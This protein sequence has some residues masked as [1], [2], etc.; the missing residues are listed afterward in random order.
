MSNAFK[1]SREDEKLKE[2]NEF[3]KMKLMLE[4]GAK[5]GEIEGGDAF[6]PQM[7]NQFLNY[8]M[9]FEKQAADHKY[10][11]VFE[12]IGKPSHF[13]PVAKIAE[14][15]IMN[16]WD[17]LLSW[18]NKYGIDLGVCSSNIKARELY[19]FTTEE[20]FEHE[21]SDMNIPG[22]TTNFIYDE[23]YPDP[24]YESEKVVNESLF[25]ALFSAEPINEYFYCLHNKNIKLNGRIYSTS[26]EVKDVFSRFKS[27]FREIKMK[28]ISIDRC[29]TK[30]ENQVIVTGKYKAV[31]ITAGNDEEVIFEGSFK[32]EL[33]PDDLGYWS[34]RNMKI[35]GINFE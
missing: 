34:I 4:N 12:K 31:A 8:I 18:M 3:L 21:M 7:E 23:F 30:R 29:H 10:I 33:F 28:N 26:D 16:A 20:L 11:K 6:S 25:P 15:D 19:R 24:I 13:K 5:F 27:F 2:E 17:E 32:I 14:E 1:N 35:E 22:M 9:E